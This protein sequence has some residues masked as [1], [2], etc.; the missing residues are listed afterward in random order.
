MNWEIIGIWLGALLTF[1]IYSFLYKD[2]PFYKFAEHLFIGMSAGYWVIYN[3]ENVL[4]PNWWYK[5]FPESGGFEWIWVIPGIFALFMLAR[6]VPKT[7]GLSR[8][9]LA[10]IVGAGAGLNMVSYF[11]TNALAQVEDTITSLS[12]GGAFEIIS[13]IVLV[14]GVVTGLVYFFF[15]KEHKGFIGKTA[16]VGITVLMVAFGASFGFTVMA[17]IS[18]LIGQVTFLLKDWLPTMGIGG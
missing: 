14:V 12:V 11:Q 2:N 1:C 17:R 5:M 3:I 13:N 4:K 10:M 16:N 15:S 7:A 18:L 8:L 6:I 9:S